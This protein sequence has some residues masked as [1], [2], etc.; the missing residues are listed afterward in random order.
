MPVCIVKGCTN[1]SSVKSR[2]QEEVE[3]TMKITLHAFPKCPTERQLWL[4]S[5]GLENSVVPKYPAICSVHFRH[6]DLDRTSLNSMC[7]IKGECNTI[8]KIT[9]NQG[10]KY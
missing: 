4:N 10:R 8:C 1:R 6:E 3:K 7:K 2:Q 9:R 5:L